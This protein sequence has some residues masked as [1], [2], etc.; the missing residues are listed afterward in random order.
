MSLHSIHVCM[1]T[2][3]VAEMKHNKSTFPPLGLH[4]RFSS[5]GTRYTTSIIF[6]DFVEL[7]TFTV[8]V[9]LFLVVVFSD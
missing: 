4:K 7:S 6:I 9:V 2:L 3:S 8:V 1:Y 5:V